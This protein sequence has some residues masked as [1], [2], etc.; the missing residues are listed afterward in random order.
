MV[1]LDERNDVEEEVISV[2]NPLTT[3]IQNV[4]TEVFYV[5]TRLCKKCIGY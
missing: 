5:C 2:W 1:I 4:C 3:Y